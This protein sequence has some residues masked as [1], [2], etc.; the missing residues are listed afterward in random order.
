[1]PWWQVKTEKVS[2]RFWSDIREGWVNNAPLTLDLSQRLEH[3]ISELPSVIALDEALKI[4]VPQV[5]QEISELRRNV[6]VEAIFLAKKATS[7]LAASQHHVLHGYCSWS[8]SS[9]YQ[10]AFFAA[11]SILYLLGI[12]FAERQNTILVDV[13]PLPEK[14]STKARKRGESPRQLIL[15]I[16][17]KAQR[18]EHQPI[19]GFFLRAIRV[20]EVEASIWP[21]NFVG[22][23]RDLREDQFAVQRNALHYKNVYW[24]FPGDLEA[25]AHRDGFGDFLAAE[26]SA[27]RFDPEAED[28]SI[29]LALVTVN[30]ALRLINDLGTQSPFFKTVSERTDG[31]L[32]SDTY[33]LYRRCLA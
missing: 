10:A 31:L 20:S 8:L 1:M 33:S 14:L 3:S 23:L 4:D 5:H 7:V 22:L 2:Q 15:A 30:L 26:L 17:L 21:A 6:L 29:M 9:A 25:I 19:W 16:K 12:A 13:W 18:L 27:D 24:P 32:A 11:K 28:F